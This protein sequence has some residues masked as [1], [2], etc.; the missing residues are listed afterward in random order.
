[1]VAVAW[2]LFFFF[3]LYICFET[4]DKRQSVVAVRIIGLLI[5]FMFPDTDSCRLKSPVFR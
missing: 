3:F 4:C 2:F 5:E 1:M